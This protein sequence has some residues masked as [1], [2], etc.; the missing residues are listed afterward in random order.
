M[1]PYWQGHEA[2]N[3]GKSREV[4][5]FSKKASAAIAVWQEGWEAG[6]L[7]QRRAEERKAQVAER[8]QPNN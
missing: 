2:F 7:V 8:S 3:P 6:D 1:N 5:P 4:S